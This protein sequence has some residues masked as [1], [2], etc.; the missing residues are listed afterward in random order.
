MAEDPTFGPAANNLAYLYSE[1]G[2]DQEKA[3]ALARTAKELMP[4]NPE[5]SDTLGWILYR[6]GDY[7]GAFR[8]LIE[9]ATKRPDNPEVQFHLG[10]AEYKMKNTEAA[11]R[12]LARALELSGDFRGN[13][14][15]RQTLSAPP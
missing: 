11:K 15:A 12:S 1:H 9:S 10:M 2:G 6:R 13:E 8:L 5:V 14:V 4:D 7:E 3:L